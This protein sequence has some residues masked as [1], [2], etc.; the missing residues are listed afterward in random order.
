MC[1]SPF[2]TGD[3][4]AT[5]A[6]AGTVA[7]TNFAVGH[8]LFH[9][10]DPL[11]RVTG[12][13]TLSRNLYMHYFIAHTWGHHRNVATP[14]DSGFARIGESFFEFLPHAV[15]GGYLDAWKYETKR[16]RA[17]REDKS[18]W[19]P[20]NRM[21]W[22]GLSNIV[23]PLL[24]Q[25][26]FGWYGMVV[27]VLIAMYSVM[28]LEAVNYVE[29]YGLLRKEL[30]PEVYEKVTIRHSWNAPHRITNYFLFRVQRHSDHHENGYKPY[31][32]LLTLEE[33]PMLPCG[34][35]MA[36]ILVFLPKLWFKI[37]NQLTTYYNKNIK[38]T[39]EEN[40]KFEVMVTKVMWVNLASLTG[41]LGAVLYSR[42]H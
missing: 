27:F 36:L 18:V 22:F 4:I 6:V 16:L 39:E 13:L 34:Y 7:A 5:L 24:V 33:S 23:M 9:K 28:V 32:T 30:S 26:I 17:L 20:Q 11:A 1:E 15:T 2:H 21:L 14:L 41:L 25:R 8:E 10:E 3:F 42:Y 29:H 38:F 40:R 37:M 31:Q 12:T 19:V 35:Y